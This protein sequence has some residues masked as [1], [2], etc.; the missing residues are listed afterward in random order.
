VAPAG[1]TAPH[2][3]IVGRDGAASVTEG[4]RSAIARVDPLTRAV[5][6]FSL[7]TRRDANLNTATFDRRGMLWFTGQNG[8]YGWLDPKSGKISVFDAPRG[9]GPYGI[10]TT[11]DG[12]V[13]AAISVRSI[14]RPGPLLFWNRP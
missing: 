14:P 4:G 1:A 7:P 9:P 8:V 2:G 10:A 3:V 11:P 13:P 6:L 12:Q 5:K